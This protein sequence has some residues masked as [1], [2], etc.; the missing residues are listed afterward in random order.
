[1]F[2]LRH[3]RSEETINLNITNK[4]VIRVLSLGIV[5]FIAWAALRQASHAIVLL[6]TGFFLAL[7]LNGP[8]H[9]L[10]VRLPGKRKG[11]EMRDQAGQ[12][13]CHG[14]LIFCG[15]RLFGGFFGAGGTAAGAPKQ[16]F[17]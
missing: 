11:G 8:V 13:L 14:N 10:A 1:M 2:S 4:T 12:G 9:W 16:Q 5:A 6:F 17:Y 7:A 15:Y 3:K